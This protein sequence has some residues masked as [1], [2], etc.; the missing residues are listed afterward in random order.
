MSS[1]Q[2]SDTPYLQVLREAGY[3]ADFIARLPELQVSR[4]RQVIMQDCEPLHQRILQQRY[5]Q[6]WRQVRAEQVHENLV[7]QVDEPPLLSLYPAA[8]GLCST[9]NGVMLGIYVA[10]CAAVWLADR[11]G[12]GMALLHS[13]KQGTLK[14][15][16]LAAVRMLEKLGADPKDLL[17]VISP[18]IRP[19]HYEIDIATLIKQQLLQAGLPQANIHD[20]QLCTGSDTASFYSYRMELGL[21]SRMLAV[22]GKPC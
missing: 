11:H 21:T 8:D 10:D 22:L 2:H 12:R 5:G 4:D 13:G 17:A 20:S 14:N 15:I 18:C 19:P 6:N 16:N 3:V 9:R 1:N 7:S